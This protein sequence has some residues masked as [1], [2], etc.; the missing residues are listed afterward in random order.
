M[1]RPGLGIG[2]ALVA[3]GALSLVEASRLRDAWHGPRLMPLVI[4]LALAAPLP[5]ATK[6]G[7]RK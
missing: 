2:A 7:I 1:R 5:L 4:G 6:M 3:L